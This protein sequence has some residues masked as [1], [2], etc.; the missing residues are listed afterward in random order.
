MLAL[1]T[2]S[3]SHPRLVKKNPLIENRV[4]L[5]CFD[6]NEKNQIEARKTWKVMNITKDDELSS[7]SPPSK[8]YAVALI[9]LLHHKDES[10]A[11]A[12]AAAFAHA[13]GM[14]I[15]TIEKNCER[16]CSIYVEAYPT[17]TDDQETSIISS[18][19]SQQGLPRAAPIA[20]KQPKKQKKVI[21]TGLP[22]K[23]KKKTPGGNL[24]KLTAGTGV[25]PK[26]RTGL[27]A[28][29]GLSA[30][31]KSKIPEVKERIIDRALL[32]DQ[33]EFGKRCDGD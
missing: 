17:Q 22:K 23:P 30:K 29:K 12:S 7:L 2:I 6:E 28:G 21:D 31:T 9:P 8:M 24:G 1:A 27:A 15:S 16:I 11:N 4:W 18:S 3:S 25:K 14:H 19:I 5:N 32:E 20:A 33:C 13:M 26:K 10:I